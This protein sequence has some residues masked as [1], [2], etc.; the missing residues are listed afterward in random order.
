MACELQQKNWGSYASHKFAIQNKLLK[1]IQTRPKEGITGWLVSPPQVLSEYGVDSSE[2]EDKQ[3]L[4][5]GVTAAQRGFRSPPPTGC[6]LAERTQWMLGWQEDS[7]GG[8]WGQGVVTSPCPTQVE[9]ICSGAHA[10]TVTIRRANVTE[11][12]KR[13]LFFI[14]HAIEAR[15]HS[16]KLRYTY[17]SVGSPARSNVHVQ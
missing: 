6:G 17:K 5:C 15:M 13:I 2:R 4:R 7:R 16:H 9:Y 1:T 12:S 11:A 8:A 3:R 14:Y 10:M